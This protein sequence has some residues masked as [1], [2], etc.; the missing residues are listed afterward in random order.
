MRRFLRLVC[1]LMVAF[2]SFYFAIGWPN[3]GIATILFEV[4]SIFLECSGYW[5]FGLPACLVV[6][7]I[8]KT[9]KAM[10]QAGYPCFSLGRK[11]MEHPGW[12]WG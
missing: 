2:G 8:Q 6:T 9:I 11:S 3:K 7:I 4:A 5:F 12:G 10:R 1:I